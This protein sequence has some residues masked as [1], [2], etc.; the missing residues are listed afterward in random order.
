MLN[1]N[2]QILLD[3]RAP[4]SKI[5]LFFQQ[6]TIITMSPFFDTVPAATS[7]VDFFRFLQSHDQ[8]CSSLCIIDTSGRRRGYLPA[9]RNGIRR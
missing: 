1:I 4:L 6:N 3:S 5:I 9:L 2:K 8:L 7:L